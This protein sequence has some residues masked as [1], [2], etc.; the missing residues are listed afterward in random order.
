[1]SSTIQRCR[2]NGC[3]HE[4]LPMIVM[5]GGCNHLSSFADVCSYIHDPKVAEEDGAQFFN[6]ISSPA[7]LKRGLQYAPLPPLATARH[8]HG[9]VTLDSEVLA[10]GGADLRSHQFYRKAERASVPPNDHDRAKVVISPSQQSSSQSSRECFDCQWES[11]AY[12]HNARAN[13]ACCVLHHMRLQSA[14]RR[15][16]KSGSLATGDAPKPGKG[17]GSPL[18]AATG[19][20]S[21]PIRTSSGEETRTGKDDGS[22]SKDCVVVVVGGENERGVLKS[23]E[24]Y[25]FA[26]RTWV[27]LPALSVGR[28]SATAAA[29]GDQVFVFGGRSENGD[30]LRTV[31]AIEFTV[32]KDGWFVRGGG[33]TTLA[34]MKQAR[35]GAA[36]VC[37]K[38][39]VYLIGGDSG[40]KPLNSVILYHTLRDVW[41]EG[42]SLNEARSWCHAYITPSRRHGKQFNDVKSDGET[43]CEEES[44]HGPLSYDMVAFGGWESTAK[45]CVSSIERWE[46]DFESDF[47]KGAMTANGV[48]SYP[49]WEKVGSMPLSS[50]EL[51][52][53]GAAVVGCVVNECGDECESPDGPSEDSKP[54]KGFV[55]V[56]GETDL[57][58]GTEVPSGVS[59]VAPSPVRCFASPINEKSSNASPLA[60]PNPMLPPAAFTVNKVSSP[61]KT[62]KVKA[63]PMKSGFCYEARSVGMMS[64]KKTYQRLEEKEA[65]RQRQRG[66]DKEATKE[67]Q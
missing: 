64:V 52:K 23:A 67:D 47:I 51:C 62:E 34:P 50:L 41:F 7:L 9:F 2:K 59:E 38:D 49:K 36:V 53:E 15:G 12:M 27:A 30:V 14:W 29:V 19:D 4:P 5:S 65:E 35:S 11:L 33:W 28:H 3:R 21:A 54:C 22:N 39:I 60:F 43:K 58:R 44:Q 61:E 66:K 63:T 32:D 17:L 6:T 42:P 10:I 16:S 56:E 20:I 57:L 26:T 25:D 13:F 37:F 48:S 46:L 40:V 24:M 55:A 31:E 8:G 45:K 1:M 18:S